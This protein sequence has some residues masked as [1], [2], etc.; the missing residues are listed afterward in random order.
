MTSL[1]SLP[2][3][4]IRAVISFVGRD[5]TIDSSLWNVARGWDEHIA[6]YGVDAMLTGARLAR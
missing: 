3:D 1:N 2:A 6:K 4:V 5:A